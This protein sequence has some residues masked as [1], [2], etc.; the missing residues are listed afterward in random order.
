[1]RRRLYLLPFAASPSP[2]PNVT[3][4]WRTKLIVEVGGI[5]QWIIDGCLA[6]LRDGLTNAAVVVVATAEYF[7][8]EDVFQQ[9]LAD[10]CELGVDYSETPTIL[11]SAWKRYAEATVNGLE[12]KS[13]LD[14]GY[15]L[16]GSSLA[17][18]G[19]KV[20]AIGT[21]YE[22]STPEMT[23]K[24]V[25][26]KLFCKR[27]QRILHYPRLCTYARVYTSIRQDPLRFAALQVEVT[28]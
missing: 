12:L 18:P 14:N 24:P 15:L 22:Y 8:S 26:C 17:I 1:M 7:K 2:R 19:P 5:L 28:K 16:L 23:T 25:A 10:A 6:Y 9:W 20:V 21:V 4:T 11:F 27:V 13:Y 3:P